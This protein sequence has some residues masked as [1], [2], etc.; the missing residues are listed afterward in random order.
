MFGRRNRQ[1]EPDDSDSVDGW[2]YYTVTVS[3]QGTEA[4]R[5]ATDTLNSMSRAGWEFVSQSSS[6]DEWGRNITLVFRHPGTSAIPTPPVD[7]EG[8]RAGGRC[9]F[10]MLL[11][12][13]VTA[14]AAIHWWRHKR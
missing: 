2:T 8:T 13:T 9:L 11:P 6:E 10:M 14:S 1:D 5:N 3:G 12:L 7:P 4:T